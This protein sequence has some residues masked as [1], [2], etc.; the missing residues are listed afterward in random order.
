MPIE[1]HPFSSNRC[2]QNFNNPLIEEKRHKTISFL[3]EI[4]YGVWMYH[5][6]IIFSSIFFLNKYLMKMG[7]FWCTF[8]FYVVVNLLTILLLDIS[9]ITLEDFFGKQRYRLLEKWQTNCKSV[10]KYTIFYAQ[11]RTF[12]A[13]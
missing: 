9:K 2:L 5:I 11:D 8:I 13:L 7:T 3:G 12:I 1:Q 10:L 4:S 6:L